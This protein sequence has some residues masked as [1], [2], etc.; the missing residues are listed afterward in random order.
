MVPVVDT[1]EA[2]L[3]PTGRKHRKVHYQEARLVAAQAQG[4]ASTHFG[5]TLHDVTD[6]GLRRAQLVQAVGWVIDSQI[7][8]R[9]DG[10]PWI[11]EQ[12]RLQF[13]QQGRYT[14]GLFHVCDYISPPP[15]I[16]P[17]PRVFCPAS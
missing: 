8:A 3:V 15:P 5:A 1:S 7:H 12:A 16:R 10:A 2:P 4:T 6:T 9:G 14:V 17:T 11:A 13:G